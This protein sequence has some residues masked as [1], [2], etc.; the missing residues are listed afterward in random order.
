M[1]EAPIG[2]YFLIRSYKHDGRIHRTWDSSIL[3]AKD[4]SFICANHQT[5]V[6]EPNGRE[7]VTKEPA[8]CFFPKREWYNIIAMLR[9]D[10]IHYYCNL[11]SPPK[12]EGSILTY[13]DYDLDL[14]VYPDFNY[15]ILDEPEFE[16][17]RERM[18]Y[19]LGTVTRIRSSLQKL[20]SDLRER[21]IPFQHDYVME[22]YE[23]YALLSGK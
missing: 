9:E 18:G 2:S 12:W 7:W 5:R 4:G 8:I 20:I 6:S 23:K 10:G 13:I 3:L 22:W 14:K 15:D 16:E 17:N 11:S 19:P 21:K 1:K